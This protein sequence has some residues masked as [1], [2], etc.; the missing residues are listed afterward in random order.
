MFEEKASNTFLSTESGHC[1]TG[2]CPAFSGYAQ[3]VSVVQHSTTQHRKTTKLLL[4]SV[5][6]A[7]SERQLLV[8]APMASR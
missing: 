8:S 2:G 7:Q 6:L 4:P 5:L 1:M 3:G